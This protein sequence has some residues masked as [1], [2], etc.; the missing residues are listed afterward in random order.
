[1]VVGVM[2]GVVFFVGLAYLISLPLGWRQQERTMHRIKS[3]AV[4]PA[5]YSIRVNNIPSH[6]TDVEKISRYFEYWG[7]VSNVT[8]C[9]NIVPLVQAINKEKEIMHQVRAACIVA[10]LITPRLTA[11]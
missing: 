1:M 11:D 5:D 6:A 3:N 2:S 4:T 9:L 8:L 10:M 7:P